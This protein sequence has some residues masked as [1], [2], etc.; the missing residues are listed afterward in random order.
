MPPAT[1]KPPSSKAIARALADYR[2]K[3]SYEQVA[4]IGTY[5]ALLLRWNQK[6][7]ITAIRDPHDILVRHFCESMYAV[8]R[9]DVKSGRLADVGSGGGFPG[10]PIKIAVP[11]LEVL[12]IE[13]NAKRAAFLAEAIRELGLT[14]VHVLVR[15][16]QELGEEIVPTE[17]V[18]ARALGDYE[19]LL[20][21]AA[22]PAPAA[23]R[24]LLWLGPAE[25]EKVT[26]IALW[27]WRE[28]VAIPHSLRRFLLIGDRIG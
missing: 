2:I 21:W 3:A 26:R 27:N 24:A 18:C 10:L 20:T 5:I 16:Y 7:N 25:I 14:R 9:G 17:Y 12:L 1:T 6:V 19:S 11:D 22:S 4:Q 13:P 15:R 8:P 28:P 23:N